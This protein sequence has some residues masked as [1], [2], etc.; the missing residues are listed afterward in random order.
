MMSWIT[1]QGAAM[2][3]GALAKFLTDLWNDR[4]A[5]EALQSLGRAEAERDQERRGREAVQRQLEAQQ[6]APR[7]ADDAI[8][9]LEDGTA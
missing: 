9:R 8:S 7:N 2:L 4:K 6:N 1:S 3:L 5:R